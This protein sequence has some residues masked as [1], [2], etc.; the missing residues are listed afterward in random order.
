MESIENQV[1]QLGTGAADA[2][3]VGAVKDEALKERLTH[4]ERSIRDVSRNV[5]LVR[6]RQV[7]LASV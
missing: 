7:A 6:D 4:I 2:K 1:E 3:D 5:Q